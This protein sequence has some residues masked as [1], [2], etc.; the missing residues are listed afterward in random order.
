MKRK[1]LLT[2]FVFSSISLGAQTLSFKHEVSVAAGGLFP[3]VG[4][5]DLDLDYLGGIPAL[6]GITR[7]KVEG[8]TNGYNVSASYRYSVTERFNVGLLFSQAFY[9]QGNIYMG[10]SVSLGKL[11]RNTSLLMLSG[12][13]TWLKIKQ[14]VTLYSK[15]N[16]GFQTSIDDFDLYKGDLPIYVGVE[17]RFIPERKNGFAWAISPVGAEIELLPHLGLFLEVGVGALGCI[18]GGIKVKL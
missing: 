13:I 3:I 9:T 2:I 7:Y 18:Q 15:F 11:R 8:A 1:L 10:A 12:Q 17:E 4:Y 14:K 6:G 5:S 16:V